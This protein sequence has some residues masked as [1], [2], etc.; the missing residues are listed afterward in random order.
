MF[1]NKV[2]QCLIFFGLFW[3]SVTTQANQ[4][5]LNLSLIL[6]DL[7]SQTAVEATRKLNNDLLLQGVKIRVYS[8]SNLAQADPA[9]LQKSNL[10]LAQITG[11][12][13]LRD[14]G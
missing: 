8:S 7:D 10:L 9:T 1:Q 2:Y 14:G 6:G 3:F 4:S 5:P 13:I 12:G 11:R